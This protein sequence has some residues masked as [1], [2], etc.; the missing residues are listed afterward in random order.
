M[1][2]IDGFPCTLIDNGMPS[3]ILA[4]SD[5]GLAGQE[6]RDALDA[7]TALKARF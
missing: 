3:V 4:A 1:H 7:D 5:F 2:T 6:S